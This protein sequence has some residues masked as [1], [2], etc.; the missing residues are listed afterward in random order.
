MTKPV[1]GRK[2]AF[3]LSQDLGASPAKLGAAVLRAAL[4]SVPNGTRAYAAALRIAGAS[5]KLRRIGAWLTPCP[6]RT[7]H[8]LRPWPGS[9]V[10]EAARAEAVCLVAEVAVQSLVACAE[11]AVPAV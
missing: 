2:R 4:R 8:G 9:S 11:V 1:S 5:L 6:S 10:L 7:V 3:C